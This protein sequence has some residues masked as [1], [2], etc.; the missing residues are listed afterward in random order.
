MKKRIIHNVIFFIN[1]MEDRKEKQFF[2]SEMGNSDKMRVSSLEDHFI[3]RKIPSDF[4]T[5]QLDAEISLGNWI[6]DLPITNLLISANY[7]AFIIKI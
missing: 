3:S 2:T 7:R 6:W 1:L 5:F 4:V